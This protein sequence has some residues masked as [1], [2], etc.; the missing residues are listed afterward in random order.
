MCDVFSGGR[1]EDRL[2]GHISKGSSTQEVIFS[3]RKKNE[4]EEKKD[5]CN[6]L[7]SMLG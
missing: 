1:R 4:Q 3:K 7:S 5:F 2:D 6:R